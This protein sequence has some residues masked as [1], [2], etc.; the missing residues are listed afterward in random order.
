GT[1]S[2]SRGNGE[3]TL[4]GS[5]PTSSAGAHTHD[6]TATFTTNPTGG[7][8][9]VSINPSHKVV[10]YIIK[11]KSNNYTYSK[12]RV[13]D[14]WNKDANQS[15][16]YMGNV[17][18]GVI[19]DNTASLKVAG[20]MEITN[21]SFKSSLGGAYF[22]GAS[23]DTNYVF[24]SFG[25]TKSQGETEIIGKFNL[26]A[27]PAEG[28]EFNMEGNM[29][30]NNSLYIFNPSGF[31]TWKNLPN[32]P[33]FPQ[34]FNGETS[35]AYS[36]LL[37]RL[38]TIGQTVNYS[39][40]YYGI[41]TYDIRYERIYNYDDVLLLRNFYNVDPSLLGILLV[42]VVWSPE[43]AEF[44]AVAILSN[45]RTIY[46]YKSTDGLTWIKTTITGKTFAC[47]AITSTSANTR[48]IWV[49]QLGLYIL[50]GDNTSVNVPQNRYN[51]LT[52]PDG[53]NWTDR[54]GGYQQTNYGVCYAPDKNMVIVCNDG[55][56][57]YSTDGCVSWTRVILTGSYRS[58][59][60]SEKKSLFVVVGTS[61][62][63]IY[64]SSNG[65][66]WTQR[67]NPLSTG[68][69]KVIYDPYTERFYAMR[70]NTGANDMIYSSDGITWTIQSVLN[71][72]GNSGEMVLIDKG[73]YKGIF[74]LYYQ[75]G[76]SGTFGDGGAFYIGFNATK[77]PMVYTGARLGLGI[78]SPSYQ[79]DLSTADA[80]KLSGTAWLTGSD[81][82]LKEDITEA[83]YKR[84]YDIVH[85]LPLKRF[86]W[87]S[88]IEAYKDIQDRHQLGWIA[89]EVE[90]FI[91]KAVKTTKDYGFD[92]IKQLD[93]DQIFKCM[94]GALKYTI[95]EIVSLKHQN[96]LLLQKLNITLEE[97]PQEEPIIEEPP[98]EVPMVEENL[99]QE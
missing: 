45:P 38:V 64:T 24:S 28:K 67:T 52:S 21:G 86:A 48:L 83:D 31:A 13:S 29:F 46:T 65:I 69:V 80:R 73:I 55:G 18:I 39:S 49:K 3:R 81:L 40:P 87:S 62:N 4:V 68:L 17:G 97:P 11:A 35:A 33:P 23:I 71:I 12:Y 74:V 95:Q 72:G 99:P 78:S 8:T 58:V 91:P 50:V 94:Y 1:V 84:C 5:N 82:R 6:F 44:L 41:S 57:L 47:P 85:Q 30:V 15:L 22:G 16:Y 43:R 59:A 20:N 54:D 98:Q 70:T 61:T 75:D 66:T 26:N 7:N 89:Q 10:N 60:Y 2:V 76:A 56:I 88:N 51:I 92:E 93:A 27:T 96:T 34:F 36:P 32:P 19:N 14:Y 42:G 79:L 90:E 9:P 63:N 77:T 25:N 53:I 37:D